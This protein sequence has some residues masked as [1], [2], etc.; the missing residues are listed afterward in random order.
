MKNKIFLFLFLIFLVW[1]TFSWADVVTVG[2]E[3]I[4]QLVRKQN[5]SVMA[6]DF[7]LKAAKDQTNHLERSF[8]PQIKASGGGE[9]FKTGNF[10]RMTQPVGDVEGTIN[11]FRSGKDLLEE[12]IRKEQVKLSETSL[13]QRYRTTL[14]HARSL[15]AQVLFHKGYLNILDKA[16]A[17]SRKDAESVK[18]RISAGLTTDS[19]RLDFEMYRH[20]LEAEEVLS[21]EDYEHSLQELAAVLGVPEG[22]ELR[23]NESFQSDH[24]GHDAELLG[25]SPDSEGHYDVQA[26]KKKGSILALQSKQAA[27]WWT[28][29]LDIYGSY[30]L[31]PFRERE[32]F[33]LGAREEAVGGVRLSLNFF[34]GLYGN[35]QKKSLAHQAVAYEHEASQ[36]KREVGVKITKYQ[37]EL[38]V[39]HDLLHTMEA[40]LKRTRDYLSLSTEEYRRGVKSS[41]EIL[42]VSQRVLDQQRRY[43]EIRRDYLITKAELLG[44]LK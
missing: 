20:Q 9:T 34:D 26:L 41:P 40:N 22:S 38:R 18:Q 23:V 7:H 12:K 19:D 17:Q 4:P 33:S 14:V 5:G 36:K 6:G 29:S 15:Y 24:H 2:F 27:R 25:E 3:D 11:V 42:M 16:L 8:L 37:H 39:R 32:R 1:P 35:A 30:A 21:Q 10:E 31:Y 43:L 13:D 44:F 28:P